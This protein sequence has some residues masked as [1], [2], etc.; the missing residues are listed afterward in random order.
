LGLDVS[1]PFTLLVLQ[2]EG[3]AVLT[4]DAPKQ[5][6]D[7]VAVVTAA[8]TAAE[9]TGGFVVIKPHP[10]SNA[11][12]PL[13]E[14]GTNHRLLLGGKSGP[15][16]DL[17]LAWW[18]SRAQNVV[19]VNS[20]CHCQS[21]A[22][23]VPTACLGR[24]WFSE[25]HVVLETD[26]MEEALLNRTRCD[27]GP[28][29]THLLSRQLRRVEYADPV[30]LGELIDWVLGGEVILADVNRNTDQAYRARA[31]AKEAK[32]REGASATE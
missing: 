31:G 7:P 20:T 18:M 11:A 16:N 9:R 21:L 1:L 10:Q 30:K 3:D 23:G 4:H 17:A 22:L 32:V 15:E 14:I 12:F 5:W 6:R 19:T 28:Y 29:L 27:G 13:P 8:V 25:N 2:R 26:S 24:G